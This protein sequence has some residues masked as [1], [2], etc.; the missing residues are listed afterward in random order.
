MAGGR[1][2]RGSC[3]PPAPQALRGG[4]GGGQ[5]AALLLCASRAA[6]SRA[7]SRGPRRL[8]VGRAPPPRSRVSRRTAIGQGEGA[9]ASADASG[10]REER[11]FGRRKKKP[12]V[13][14][15]S[16]KENTIH[17][18]RG[19]TSGEVPQLWGSCSRSC[20]RATTSK[21]HSEWDR[22]FSFPTASLPHRKPMQG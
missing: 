12:L 14:R 15:E 1:E 9:S 5:Q 11:R 3:G 2:P 8:C 18:W 21:I 6:P 19:A 10:A 17:V 22:A 20:T 4:A 13:L 7:A 16:D